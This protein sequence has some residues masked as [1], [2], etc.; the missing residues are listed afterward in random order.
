FWVCAA[1]GA[2]WVAI[3]R[4]W[5]RNSPAEHPSISRAE[6]EE[7][8]GG[9]AVGPGHS[10][11]LALFRSRQLWLVMLMYSCYGW[12]SY[13][14]L[15]WLHTYLVK[16]LGLT[17]MEMGVFSTLPFILGAGANLAGGWLSDRMV[18]SFGLRNGRRVGGVI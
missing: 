6:R 11:P 8:G 9:A 18:R 3:W 1:L 5:Y 17:E 2:V 13:F 15:S 14:Y 12:G 7:I 4:P 16:G 10:I